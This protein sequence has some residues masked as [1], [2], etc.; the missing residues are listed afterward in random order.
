[1]EALR[2]R[3]L[4][5][6]NIEHGGLLDGLPSGTSDFPALDIAVYSNHTFSP[7]WL[8]FVS[9]VSDTSVSTHRPNPEINN[10][11][12]KIEKYNI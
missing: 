5:D 3:D 6:C 8:R 10:A 7:V 11:S 12:A 1:M 9:R 4:F 2:L